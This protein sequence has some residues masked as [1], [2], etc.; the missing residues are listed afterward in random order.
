MSLVAEPAPKRSRR[1]RT[2]ITAPLPSGRAHNDIANALMLDAQLKRLMDRQRHAIA[3][4]TDQVQLI[5]RFR[6]DGHYL[7]P[8]RKPENC[9]WFREKVDR[10][11][12][13]GG[14][15]ICQGS[16]LGRGPSAGTRRWC[17]QFDF[18]RVAHVIK[19]N[20]HE[21]TTAS[22]S[23]IFNEWQNESAL[24]QTGLGDCMRECAP[25]R[26]AVREQ[27]DPIILHVWNLRQL[28]E[29]HVRSHSE[30]TDAWKLSYNEHGCVQLP[31]LRIT[32]RDIFPMTEHEA[33]VLQ[34]RPHFADLMHREFMQRL[35]ASSGEEPTAVSAPVAA[36]AAAAA[37]ASS[38]RSFHDD[39]S[40]LSSVTSD[41]NSVD[42]EE[43]AEETEEEKMDTRG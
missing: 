21:I 29:E 12:G 43:E 31:P 6:F 16:V 39:R 19:L 9:W 10:A 25:R 17:Y 13:A 34:R 30:A 32:S 7:P 33:Q 24:K 20:W 4:M 1:A 8:F 28:I 18:E 22:L 42:E 26:K 5:H 2:V 14:V 11:G 36:A 40:I 27:L 23:S 37:A 15:V 3:R 41:Y 35:D 38:I